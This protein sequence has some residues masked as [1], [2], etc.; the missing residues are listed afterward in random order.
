[1][2]YKI[3]IEQFHLVQKKF[4]SIHDAMEIASAA[5]CEVT[6]LKAKIVD[7]RIICNRRY[8]DQLQKIRKLEA[9]KMLQIQEVLFE[10]GE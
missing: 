3:K 8:S 7:M 5:D 2:S 10:D 6:K 9:E 4:V 1:M